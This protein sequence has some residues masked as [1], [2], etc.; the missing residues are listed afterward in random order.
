MSTL[1]SKTVVITDFDNTLYDWFEVW[2][3]SFSALV[4]DV[5]KI[6]G[7][8]R[9]QL[10]SEI[11]KVHEKHGTTEYS[12]LLEELPSLRKLYSQEQI[13][14]VFDSSIHAFRSARKQSLKLYPG[15]L[16]TLLSLTERG[17][18]IASY[19]ESL[20]Y[21]TVYRMKALKLDGLISYLYSS[22][23]HDNPKN[24]NV[25][26]ERM[27]SEE[28]YKL[29]STVHRNTVK[30]TKKP[31]AQVLLGIVKDI[32]AHIDECVY[33]GDSLSRDVAMA[34]DAGICSVFAK[35]GEAHNDNRYKLLEE[36]THWTGDEVQ[37]LQTNTQ[38]IEPKIVL[39]NS[40]D[41]I[42]NHFVFNKFEGE[43]S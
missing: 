33:I 2:H 29:D 32:G 10:L 35:Y 16:P 39:E 6:T 25:Q 42:L 14:T 5:I 12:W 24:I 4:A 34:N 31:N 26:N 30:G 38:Q 9:Q 1:H 19:T 18:M 40:F 22:P 7:L 28:Y 41:E 43:K 20:A 3:E 23:D 17:V 37:K 36:V 11:K 27:Y 13:K 21:P 15:V 8:E